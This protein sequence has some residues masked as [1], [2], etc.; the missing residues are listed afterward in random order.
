M[1]E[2][3]DIV[4][5]VVR[6]RRPPSSSSSVGPTFRPSCIVRRRPSFVARHPSSVVAGASALASA[7][8]LIDVYE[9]NMRS[10][11]IRYMMPATDPK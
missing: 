6:R 5:V 10:K 3:I 7:P 1:N 4:V 8:L 9:Q 11:S 2:Y